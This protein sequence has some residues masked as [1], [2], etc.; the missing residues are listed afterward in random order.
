[1][2]AMRQAS[3]IL[4]KD[5]V[6]ELRTKEVL[7]GMLVFALLVLVTCNIAFDLR[8]DNIADVAPG[9][10][11]VA[12]IFA[13]T[14]GIG[15][16]FVIERDRGSLAGLLLAPIDREAIYLAKLA[17]NCLF[18]FA[19][20]AVT[21]AVFAAFFHLNVLQFWLIAVVFLGTLGFAAVGTVFAAMAVHTR[22]REVLLPVLLFPIAIPVVLG[23]VKATGSL[24]AATAD[25]EYLL[26]TQ[27]LVAF[28]AIFLVLSFLVFGSVI[29]E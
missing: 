10:L 13:G 11:W 6:C 3:V 2:Q 14:L 25:Q 29:E 22:A 19:M 5:V 21:L 16:S 15:R 4:W 20:E 27:L 8:V 24:L 9:V 12:I 28:D 1:M 17:G 7:G 23:A 18:M 26:W